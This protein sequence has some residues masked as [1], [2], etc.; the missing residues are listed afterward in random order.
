MQPIPAGCTA[1]RRRGSLHVACRSQQAHSAS[2]VVGEGPLTALVPVA[3]HQH[4]LSLFAANHY[5]AMLGILQVPPADWQG[6][7]EARMLWFSVSILLE[8]R[9]P[10]KHSECAQQLGFRIRPN[11]AVNDSWA[12]GYAVADLPV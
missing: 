10:S 11:F 2:A 3:T 8:L 9:R 4:C 12:P 7:V 1:V 6:A 5:W